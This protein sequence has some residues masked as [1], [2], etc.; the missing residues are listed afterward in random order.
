MKGWYGR[1]SRLGSPLTLGTDVDLEGV[2][3]TAAGR[4][5]QGLLQAGLVPRDGAGRGQRVLAR[6]L[7]AACG[8][9]AVPDGLEGVEG[10][11][12]TRLTDDYGGSLVS[13]LHC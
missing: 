10:W 8:V 1:G 3:Q 12:G 5:V 11:K 4:H 2:G 7:H 13:M 9:V 6:D